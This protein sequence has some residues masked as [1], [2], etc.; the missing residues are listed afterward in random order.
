MIDHKLKLFCLIVQTGSFS[1][2]AEMTGLTQPGV[3]R[4]IQTLEDVYNA[5]L[6]NRQGGTVTLTRAGERLY[7]Y[8]EEIN[9]HF[10]VI[11]NKIRSLSS[12]IDNTIRI[13]SCHTMGNFILPDIATNFNNI[14]PDITIDLKINAVNDV[15]KNLHDRKLDVA[16]VN[17]DIKKDNLIVNKLFSDEM[18]LIML[19]THKLSAKKMISILDIMNEPFIINTN[20]TSTEKI[21]ENYLSNKGLSTSNLH[22]VLKTGTI[23]SAK[24]AVKCGMGVSIIP[25]CSVTKNR[26]NGKTT[27]TSFREGKL[28]NNY[29]LVYRKNRDYSPVS[30]KFIKYL[31]SY[32]FH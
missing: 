30:F 11:N 5:R 10:T 12:T 23:E 28:T 31:S 20:C 18:V 13:G 19:K 15:I 1:K 32:P 25:K 4:Q 8:A 24:R 21:F 26:E 16:L 9:S 14:N 3:S 6:L 17:G 22:I 29:S 2:A 27:T 7:K